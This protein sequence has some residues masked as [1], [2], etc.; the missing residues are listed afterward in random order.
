MDNKT[1]SLFSYATKELSQD[2]FFCW[3]LEW[4]S[5][6]YKNTDLYSISKNFIKS[7]IGDDITINKIVIKR[8]YK[9]I[10]FYIIINDNVIISFEDKVKSKFHGD[11]LQ[12]YKVIMEKKYPNSKKIF[13]YIKTDLI[14]EKERIEVE[15]NGYI[16]I[17]IIKLKAILLPDSKN[18]IYQDFYVILHQK[19]N[20]FLNFENI[21]RKNWKRNEW[22]G[23]F[24]KLSRKVNY[25]QFW[26]F[27]LGETFGF[28]LEW[29]SGFSE[30]DIHIILEIGKNTFFIKLYFNNTKIERVKIVNKYKKLFFDIFNGIDIQKNNRIGRTTKLISFKDFMKTDEEN[31]LDFEKTVAYIEKI[32]NI[33]LDGIKGIK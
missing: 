9:F 33:F 25:Y 14:M 23:F 32:R 12:K 8:Q 4:S 6:K 5:E 15:K 22:L 21:D 30:K 17:D 26:D 2:A 13:V 24:Y 31:N 1:P 19:I 3:L 29:I 28:D 20:S 18:N 7:I 16:I 27:Y 11:Q 10:D